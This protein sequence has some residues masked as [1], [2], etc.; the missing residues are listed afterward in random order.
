MSA[1]K[2]KKKEDKKDEFHVDES[3]LQ[4]LSERIAQRKIEDSDWDTLSRYLALVLRLSAA[5]QF[6]KIKM[7]RI[8]RILFGKRTEKEKKKDPPEDPKPPVSAKDDAHNASDV[9]KQQKADAASSDEGNSEKT[10]KGHGRHSVSEFQNTAVVVCRHGH[11]KP[12]DICSDC[13]SG[14]LYA[15]AAEVIIRFKGNPPITGTKYEQEKMRCNTCGAI[16]KADLPEGVSNEKYDASAKVSIVMNKYSMGTPFYR[17]SVQ[18]AQQLIPLAASVQ[19]ELVEDAANGFLPVWLEFK[20]LVARADLI[21]I[22]D[23]PFKILASGKRQPLTGIV[24]R[25][26]E[27]WITLY[28]TGPEAAGKKLAEILKLRPPHL[29]P[30]LQMS[31]AL[32]GNQ[33]DLVQVIVLLCMVHCRRQFFEIKDFYPE[34]CEPVLE[35]IRQVYHS[36][37]II[38][39]LKLDATDRLAYHQAHSLPLLERMRAWLQQQCDQHLIEPNSPLGKAVQYLNKHWNGLTGFCRHEGAPLDSNPVERALKM[40]IANRKNSYFFRTDHGASVG[41]LLMSMIKTATQ[42]AV[43]P[44]AY[45][46]AL[47]RNRTELRKNPGLWMP[48]NYQAQLQ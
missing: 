2:K 11:H 7:K 10:V 26:G 5:L 27:R 13:E 40:A 31:D 37:R 15:L 30:P 28:L 6:G 25:T 43:S 34:V 47:L 45:L 48:W 22:D 19:W 39:N 42:A 29:S 24:A 35:A 33:Q 8:T 41:C 12:G 21:F 36:E 4:A 23:T 32:A 14:R 16:F 18:Q 44:F 9:G 17:F 1:H 38:Q 3:E 20:R 46:E